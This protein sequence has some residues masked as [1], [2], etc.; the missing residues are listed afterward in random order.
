MSTVDWDR[1]TA[2]AKQAKDL[3]DADRV[4][5]LER[6]GAESRPLAEAVSALLLGLSQADKHPNPAVAE[7]G[8]IQTEAGE[9]LGA[10]RIIDTIGQG[11]MGSVFL[12]ER[13]DREFR[14]KVAI[15]VVGRGPLEPRTAA[16]LKGERQIL[17]SLEHPH[18][19]RL[20][21]GGTTPD[22]VPFLV[23]EYIKGDNL[24]HYCDQRKLDVRTRL[25]LFLDICE[26]VHY[27]HRNLIVHRDIKP[28]NILVTEDGQVKLLDFGIAKMLET[29]ESDQTI[30]LT[31]ANMVVMTPEYASP[32]QALGGVITT[33]SDIFAL[34]VV[35]YE[36]LT[37]RVP[38]RVSMRRPEQLFRAI[39][40]ET[41]VS[42]S[43]MVLRQPPP[44]GERRVGG[45]LPRT[46]AEERNTTPERLAR[47][48]KGELDNIVLMALRKEPE[49]RYSSVQALAQD[50]ERYLQDLPVA[51]Q[52]DSATYRSRKFVKRHWVGLA[53]TT[54][55]VLTAVVSAVSFAVQAQRISRERDVAERERSRAEQ[56]SN[57][58]VELTKISDPYRTPTLRDMVAEGMQKIGSL[59]SEPGLQAE[60]MHTL[61]D[62]AFMSGDYEG[63]LALLSDALKSRET[64][65]GTDSVQVA[66]TRNRIGKTLN[67]LGRFDQAL[68]MHEQALAIFETSYGPEN[69]AV[70]ETLQYKGHV[71]RSTDRLGQAEQAYRKS[72]SLLEASLGKEHYHVAVVSSDLAA[73]LTRLGNLTDAERF[74]REALTIYEAQASESDPEYALR[75]SGLALVLHWQGQY[76][77]AEDLYETATD[78]LVEVLGSNHP[79]VAGT[80]GNF[81]RLLHDRG[82]LERAE[83]LFREALAANR[84]S[85]GDRHHFVA[86]DQVNLAVLLRDAGQGAEAARL[87]EDALAV[88]ADK[89]PRNHAYVGA[90]L[91]AKGNVSIDSGD[92]AGAVPLLE[93]AVSIFEASLPAEH[94]QIANAQC[95]L[96][97]A[98]AQAGEPERARLLFSR[99]LGVLEDAWGSGHRLTV[100]A[101]GWQ[102]TP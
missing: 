60:L 25:E 67:A 40:Q 37:G 90:A 38:H 61:G 83:R 11:G 93:E 33:S 99:G 10:Y 20:L 85:L 64:E 2:L 84:E 7:S 32:E 51:A 77:A 88:Y 68:Q 95:V 96:A 39:C 22:G 36:L 24:V 73:V 23:M 30:A 86:Y 79:D 75:Q 92:A 31:Q 91:V 48:L 42:P 34:G 3:A 80:K 97:R 6:L 82:K 87:L 54:A 56:V 55:L 53:A 26:A 18:V 81:A 13:A 57:F 71:F 94:W 9:R 76:Q 44:E 69:A 1:A 65:F 29:Q 28:S 89:L 5:F 102:A 50:V 21:D 41:P 63:S 16:R 43:A 46:I 101:R 17:A 62:I 72:R 70:G 100:R 8:G 35:L 49:R 74:Y 47:L 12:A 4:G 14:K 58:I 98:L 45:K 27:A 78:T 59:N 15:K 52:P 66:I 19:A